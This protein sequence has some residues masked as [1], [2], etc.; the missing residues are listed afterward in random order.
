MV[1]GGHPQ[2]LD[3]LVDVL[4]EEP[5]LD[6]VGVARNEN[7]AIELA[8]S[9]EPDLFVIDMES[10]GANCASVIRDLNKYQPR[11]RLVALSTFDDEDAVRRTLDIGFHRH[12]SKVFGS[13]ELLEILLEE[14]VKLA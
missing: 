11:I 13:A 1:V 5:E 8:H 10:L 9:T 3:A 7:E 6:V 2:L 14:H 4:S 12:V